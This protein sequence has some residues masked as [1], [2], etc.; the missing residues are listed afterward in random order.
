MK[1]IH[2]WLGIIAIAST[3]VACG[4]SSDS[5]PLPK[6]QAQVRVIHAS[7]DAPN[8][9][10]YAGA[11]KVLT[12][13]PYKAAS[14]LLTVDAGDFPVKV[15]PTGSTTGVISAT[16]KL[17]KDTVTTVIA[18]NNVA[19]I[20]PLVITESKMA[21]ADGK[22][23]VRVVHAAPAAPAVDVYV[24]APNAAIASATPTLSNV[25]FKGFSDGLEVAAGDYQVRVTVAGSKTVVY[26]SGK[27]AVPAGADLLAM[28]IPQVNGSSPISLLLISRAAT[29]NVTEVADSNAKLRVVHASPDAPAVDVLANGSALLSNVPFFTASNYLTVPAAKYTTALQVSGTTTIALTKDLTLDRA[30]NYTVFAVGYAAKTPALQYLVGMDDASLPP[31]G[32]SKVR[33]VHASPDAPAV[34]VYANDQLVMS[35]VAFPAIGDYLKVPAG[36]Y[37]FKLRAAGAAASSA[38][39]FTS[40]TVTTADGKIYT[41]VA[42]GEFAQAGTSNATAFT[43]TVLADN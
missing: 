34:D 20:E 35:N 6:D 15:T 18:V 5:T 39:A 2:Q 27:L 21:P 13:V 28:A 38:P 36:P 4:G 17:A 24:T 12:D 9:D 1:K 33:V 14:G 16:L 3:L 31:A 10:V 37:V 42:R 40:P 19:K 11:A 30:K 29:G 23:R 26:D 25:P 32:Q 43:L 7:A 22:G 8:V 41:V